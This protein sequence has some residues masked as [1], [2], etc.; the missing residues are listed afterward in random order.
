MYNFIKD[1]ENR[2][3]TLLGDSLTTQYWDEYMTSLQESSASGEL[4]VFN[5]SDISYS[6]SMLNQCESENTD[7]CTDWFISITGSLDS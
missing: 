7:I 3:K 4:I 5:D 2:V 1:N 6:N